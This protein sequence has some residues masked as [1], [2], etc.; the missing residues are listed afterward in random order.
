MTRCRGPNGGSTVVC[1]PY[2]ELL[3]DLIQKSEL[4]G[5]CSIH[6]GQETRIY[7]SGA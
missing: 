2:Q 7:G 3:G 5:V 1:T 6:G 4:G